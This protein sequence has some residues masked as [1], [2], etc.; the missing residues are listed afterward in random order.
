MEAFLA[1]YVGKS[2]FSYSE[3]EKQSSGVF[4]MAS[5]FDPH[6]KSTLDAF[7]ESVNQIKLAHFSD[8]DVDEAK[9]AVFARVDKPIPPS[10]KVCHE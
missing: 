4:S 2:I 9:L 10:G 5:Y 1:R 8:N 6:T 3:C 7:D